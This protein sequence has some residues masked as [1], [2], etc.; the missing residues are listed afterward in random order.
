MRHKILLVDDEPSVLTGLQRVLAEEPYDIFTAESGDEALSLLE[1]ISIDL[2]VADQ[3]MPGMC[4]TELLSAVYLK[5][6]ASVRIML[7]G[8]ATTE[9]AIDAINKGAV[10]RLLTK[11]CSADDLAL[12]IHQALIQKDI[13]DES[14]EL[15]AKENKQLL[16]MNEI[17]RENP[18]I[19][20][21]ETDAHGAIEI[22]E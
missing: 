20:H 10:T 8:K 1:E 2:I 17:E 21:I 12:A 14:E 19:T 4:G 11:P 7:T 9:V 13:R 22:E 15:V 6:P 16:A 3:D 5:Y 18:G